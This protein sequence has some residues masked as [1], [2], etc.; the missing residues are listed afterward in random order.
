MRVPLWI[1]GGVISMACFIASADPSW[2][3]IGGLCFGV[4]GLC[5][6]VD[7]LAKDANVR[8]KGR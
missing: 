3:V 2:G 1:A 6:E 8:D 7:E 4:A 5:G